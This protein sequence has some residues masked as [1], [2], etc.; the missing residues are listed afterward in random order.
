MA[1]FYTIRIHAIPL[2]DASGT[3][4]CTV[5]ASAF[6][7]AIET[8]NESSSQQLSGSRSIRPGTGIPGATPP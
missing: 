3:R 1:L 7:A 8:V 6:A 5:T 4:A 2:T